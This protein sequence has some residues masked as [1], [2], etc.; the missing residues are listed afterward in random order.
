MFS[1]KPILSILYSLNLSAHFA[2]WVKLWVAPTAPLFDPHYFKEKQNKNSR[3][4]AI[5][6]VSWSCYPDLNWGPHPYQLTKGC[7][8][9]SLVIVPYRLGAVAPQR[10]AKFIPARC[11]LLSYLEKAC[12]LVP[13]SVL[14]QFLFS[15]A[16]P[17]LIPTSAM[18]RPLLGGAGSFFMPVTFI[19]HPS[20]VKVA[21]TLLHSDVN[22]PPPRRSGAM[23]QRQTG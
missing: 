15:A 23:L 18:C 3:N 7:Y 6:G 20:C 22:A 9:L 13:V 8:C 4:R 5:S 12:F 14:C 16:P 2:V 19:Y 17:D 1:R 11:C 10:L 21:H